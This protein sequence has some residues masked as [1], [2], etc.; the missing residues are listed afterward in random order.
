MGLRVSPGE[1]GAVLQE[2]VCMGCSEHAPD[3]RIQ[4]MLL[5]A[6]E[7]HPVK[8]IALAA[9]MSRCACTRQEMRRSAGIRYHPYF[10]LKV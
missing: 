1:C 10:N 6:L 4:I 8:F 9:G 5:A 3:T 2:K 7:V